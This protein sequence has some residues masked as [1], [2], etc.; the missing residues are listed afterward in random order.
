MTGPQRQLPPRSAGTPH[1]GGPA[2]A[3]PHPEGP[4]FAPQPG[5]AVWFDIIR[6]GVQVDLWREPAIIPN[7]PH[8]A[9]RTWNP[10][11]QQTTSLT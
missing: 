7:A 2:L 11:A 3:P 1:P 4:P 10:A 9:A 6:H 8:R 5:D